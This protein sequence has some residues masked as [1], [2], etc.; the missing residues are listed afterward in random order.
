MPRPRVAMRKI[1]E[2]LRLAWLTYRA[3]GT[4]REE[5]FALAV[6]LARRVYA[7]LRR[8]GLPRG[9]A[10]ASRRLLDYD[11]D[12]LVL[13]A[14][15][16]CDPA[17]QVEMGRVVMRQWLTLAALGYT[18]HPLSQV[19]DFP[20]TR[21]YLA[22][23]LGIEDGNRLLNLARVGRPAVQPAHSARRKQQP[24]GSE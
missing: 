19:I 6:V 22:H 21:D 9:P 24:A 4:S 18:T 12:V 15:P 23:A 2:V 10:G 16:G 1:R 3:L 7:A 5:A 13:I 8:I 20:V 14:P 17:G 11:G